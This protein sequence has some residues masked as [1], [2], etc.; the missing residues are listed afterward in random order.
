M[1]TKEVQEKMH[2]DETRCCS[3]KRKR[4]RITKSVSEDDDEEDA[5]Y[6]TGSERSMTPPSKRRKLASRRSGYSNGY[7]EEA[8][9]S[10]PLNYPEHD[11]SDLLI[12]CEQTMIEGDT[13]ILNPHNA[14]LLSEDGNDGEVVRN[15]V[16]TAG[17]ALM[18]C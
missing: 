14:S 1:G 11:M 6:V 7:I 12:P 4:R 5:L 16:R 13:E 9:K 15:P 2:L 10:S 3:R 8:A 17:A 18:V